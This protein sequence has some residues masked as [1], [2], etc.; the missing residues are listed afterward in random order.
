[1]FLSD[2]NNCVPEPS[3]QEIECY[4]TYMVAH[5]PVA[6]LNYVSE[7]TLN[8]ANCTE[9]VSLFLKIIIINNLCDTKFICAIKR[10]ILM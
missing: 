4:P 3:L 10:M 6:E 5:F 2:F 8:D 1:M 7:L 9:Q